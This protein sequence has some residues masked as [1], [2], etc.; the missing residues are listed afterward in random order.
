MK[1]LVFLLLLLAWLSPI[2]KAQSQDRLKRERVETLEGF[3]SVK[4]GEFQAERDVMPANMAH[5]M[6]TY[7]NYL[8]VSKNEKSGMS[9]IYANGKVLLPYRYVVRP[10]RMGNTWNDC[11]FVLK[12]FENDSYEIA[13][14]MEVV[15]AYGVQQT[16]C[17]SVVSITNDGYV[18]K[19][20]D[21]YYYSTYNKQMST[22]QTAQIVWL[23]K[24]T[25]KESDRP[26]LSS[27]SVDCMLSEGDVYYSCVGK[28]AT[29]YYY[30]YRDKYMPNTV[31]IVD[32]EPIE[33]FGQYTYEDLKVKFSY[34]GRHWMAVAN[35]RFW[36]D[37]EMKL[38]EGYS[39]SDFLISNKGD[40]V[41]KASKNGE[42]D[43]GETLVQNGDILRR[44]VIVGHFA[45]TTQQKL[46]FH[47]LAAGHWYVYEDGQINSVTKESNSVF[48]P[49]DLI[50]NLPIDKFSAD[51]MHKLSYV[52]GQKGVEIDGVRMTES[53]PF[54]VFF[55]KNDKCFRW[56]AIEVNREGKTDLVV[57]TY[58]L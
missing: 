28:S 43:K 8:Y 13:Y 11:V 12:Y 42:E 56:N 48:Y 23:E 20:N 52:T 25:F 49:E 35:D 50:D 57:Y 2:A 9:T 54:Q 38:V 47:F 26:M 53:V 27:K 17:D 41:Y 51:G 5:S 32:G 15:Y 45:F 6:T 19:L 4:E 24:K 44:Q 29:H 39:I 18:Y 31:L 46:R 36:V 14:G 55:D 10:F 22:G 7:Y 16:V 33:L 37:G 30:L 3:L 58:S 34:N 40:Y 21:E 1:R